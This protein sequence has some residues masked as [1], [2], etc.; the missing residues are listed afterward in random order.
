VE[1]SNELHCFAG[2]ASYSGEAV[3]M[4]GKGIAELGEFASITL[5]L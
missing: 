4:A 5:P 2:L 3:S 1:P